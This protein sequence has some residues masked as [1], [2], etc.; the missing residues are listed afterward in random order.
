MDGLTATQTL[1]SSSRFSNL[2]TKIIACTAFTD[3][4][5]KLNWY[6]TQ[7]YDSYDVGM[8]FI[9]NKPVRKEEL[10]KIF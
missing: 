3:T 6:L 5:T 9:I 8:D 2:K 1:K 10:Y 7:L 4:Q